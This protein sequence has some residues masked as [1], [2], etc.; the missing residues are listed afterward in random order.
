LR[1]DLRALPDWRAR[2]RLLQEHLFPSVMYMRARYGV[3]S[4]VLVPALYLWR[5]VRGAPKWLSTRAAND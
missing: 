4:N 1:S 2:A 5:I 3:Q